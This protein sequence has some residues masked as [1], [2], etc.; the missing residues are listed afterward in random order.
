MTLARAFFLPSVLLCFSL[1]A[2]VHIT[3]PLSQS[4]SITYS[5]SHSLRVKHV[6]LT[7]LR[8]FTPFNI[9]ALFYID[10]VSSLSVQIQSI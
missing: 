1:G 6:G 9:G 5:Y 7:R 3:Y 10:G 8:V 4:A 2:Y